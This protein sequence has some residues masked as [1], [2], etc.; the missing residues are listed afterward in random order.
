[1]TSARRDE[2]SKE[3]VSRARSTLDSRTNSSTNPSKYTFV[4]TRM[5]NRRMRLR[6]V[7]TP[8]DLRHV[9]EGWVVRC[10]REEEEDRECNHMPAPMWCND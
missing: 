10:V 3:G 7:K 5:Q 2:S 8:R 1:M 6:S 4:M 9:P